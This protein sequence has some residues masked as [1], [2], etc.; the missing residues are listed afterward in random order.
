MYEEEIKK[1]ERALKENKD[2]SLED[3][4]LFIYNYVQ[5][6]KKVFEMGKEIKSLPELREKAYKLGY[7][8]GNFEEWLEKR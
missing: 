8:I 2:T 6:E 5:A 4:I 3:N 1:I 7:K